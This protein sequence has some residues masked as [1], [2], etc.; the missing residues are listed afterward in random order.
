[1]D[2][3]EILFNHSLQ[4]MKEDFNNRS[5]QSNQLLMDRSRYYRIS[6]IIWGAPLL[7][8]AAILKEGMINLNEMSSIG[9]SPFVKIVL[10]MSFILASLINSIM[11]NSIINNEVS[12]RLSTSGMNYLRDL[13]FKILIDNKVIDQDPN[14]I[15]IINIKNGQPR[16]RIINSSGNQFSYILY[17]IS[18]ILF[19]LIGLVLSYR[20]FIF[21]NIICTILFVGIVVTH[22]YILKFRKINGIN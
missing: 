22:I 7:I 19:A 11:L 21:Y 8:A 12:V 14:L 9:W 10:S 15:N 4:M 18:N 6:V 13:Y 2:S 5:N 20:S 17:S 3:N 16:F 1:M